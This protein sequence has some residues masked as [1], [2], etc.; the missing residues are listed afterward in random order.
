MY[1]VW[2]VDLVISP[3]VGAGAS[4]E[5]PSQRTFGRRLG[6]SWV[7]TFSNNH[8]C[9]NAVSLA[10]VENRITCQIQSQTELNHPETSLQAPLSGVPPKLASGRGKAQTALYVRVTLLK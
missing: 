5:Q 2:D 7:N 1:R 4:D 10:K 9:T 3:S 6:S 8:S